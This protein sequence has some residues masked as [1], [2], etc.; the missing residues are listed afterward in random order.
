MDAGLAA[1][2]KTSKAAMQGLNPTGRGLGFSKTYGMPLALPS[3]Q[4]MN[5]P[6][7]HVQAFS[8]IR[9]LLPHGHG[10]PSRFHLLAAEPADF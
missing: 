5:K 2:G 10:K 7:H 4:Q 6:K 9:A 3:L 8:C 1:P